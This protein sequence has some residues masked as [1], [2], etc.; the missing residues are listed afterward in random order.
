LYREKRCPGVRKSRKGGEEDMEV[1]M[2]AKEKE[3]P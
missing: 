1:V 3:T 2:E